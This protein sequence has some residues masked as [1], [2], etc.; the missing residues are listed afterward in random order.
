MKDY[1]TILFDLDGTLTDP[2]LGITNSVAYALER[3]GITVS[4]RT[5]L[6]KFIGPP[7]RD[8]FM[9]YYG[10]TPGEAER[11]VAVYREYY[12]VD[13]LFENEVYPGIPEL[14]A[15]L[16]G[17]GKRLIVATSKPEGFS[18]RILEHFGLMKHFDFVAGATLDGSRGTKIEVMNHAITSCG[19][20]PAD[21]V[22]IG[23]REF[24]ILGAK[25]FGLASIGVLFGY[26][27]REE[28]TKA[29]ADRLAAD[30]TELEQLLCR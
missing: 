10:F 4:D 24:D 1:S 6:Y 9:A 3:F 15:K 28:L 23:D 19:V 25:H 5:S 11:A 2:G 12:S 21:A 7:L 14:L 30:V 27:S 29:G 26:G 20:D 22:M 8:S 18:A 17:A 13:G 16:K